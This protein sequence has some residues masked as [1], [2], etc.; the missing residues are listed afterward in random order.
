MNKYTVSS[1]IFVIA[2]IALFNYYNA[3]DTNTNTEPTSTN[4]LVASAVTVAD[5]SYD[6]GEIDI[7]GGKVQTT[8]TL[9]NEGMEDV[10]IT[11]AVTSC[12][13]TEGE[14][15]G[16][17]FGMHESAGQK[18]TIPAG[19]EKVL[20]AIYDPLAH[21]PDGTG[22]ITRELMLETN[23]KLTPRIGVKFSA[24]VVKYTN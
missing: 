4:A 9:K 19:G 7:F 15:G 22:K 3:T 1:I 14:I 10:Q 17:R 8:Y 5:S 16:M 6:F 24:N 18:I 21:G 13:C 11:S 2:G 23:S 12:M 20:T